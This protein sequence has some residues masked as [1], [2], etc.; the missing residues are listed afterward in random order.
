MD[1]LQKEYRNM[2]NTKPPIF[3]IMVDLGHEQWVRI[4]ATSV[5]VRRE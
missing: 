3:R 4:K 1:K 2:K 5:S